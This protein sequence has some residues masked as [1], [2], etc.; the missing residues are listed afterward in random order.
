MKWLEVLGFK[1]IPVG[2][3][4]LKELEIT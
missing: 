1:V 4:E 2:Y 3:D